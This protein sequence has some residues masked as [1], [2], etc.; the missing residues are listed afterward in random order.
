MEIPLIILALLILASIVVGVYLFFAACLRRKELPW[1]VE[2]KIKNTVYAKY[3]DYIVKSHNWLLEHNAEDVFIKSHDGLK[4][5]GLWVPAKDPKGTVLLAH[6]YRS[7]MLVDFGA[8]MDFYHALG[9]NLLLPEQ[10]SHGKSEGKFITFGVKESQDMQN[11]IAYHNQQFGNY[12]MILDGLSMGASTVLYLADKELPEN[13][14]GIIADC[15]FTSPKDI[16]SVV[17]RKVTHL[18]GIP[19]I[20][21]AEL[22]ARVFG[23]FS[24]YGCDSRKILQNSRLPVIMVHGTA[25]DFVPCYMTRAG[26]DACTSPKQ[27]LLAEGATHGVSFF[28]EKERY[29]QM[30]TGF[31][32]QHVQNG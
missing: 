21:I 6:G 12:P 30:I 19:F 23:K 2:A 7:T 26:Y 11:W 17:F 14:K 31:L 20:W 27:L 3:Y 8:V 24:F 32:D 1:L 9:M 25:D 15:G 13:V 28:V 16:I 10:R 4:L 5:H 22:C 18:P 29:M